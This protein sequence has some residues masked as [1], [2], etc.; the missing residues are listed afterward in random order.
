MPL[1]L[2]MVDIGVQLQWRAKGNAAVGRANVKDIA[3]VA[4]AGVASGI[5]VA[6]YVVVGGRLAPA[7]VSPI[8]GAGVRGR[9]IAR[10]ATARAT[11][12]GSRVGVSPGVASVGGPKDE[13]RVVVGEASAAFVHTGDVHV[14]C[15]QIAGDLDV[16]DK[17]SAGGNLSRVCPRDPIV[18]RVPDKEGAPANIEV[19]PRNVHPAVEGRRWVIVSPARLSV[20][21]R[22]RVNAVMGPAIRV[23]GSGGLVPAEAKTAAGLVDPDGEPSAGWLVI[24]N[25]WVAHR[26]GEGAVT[27]GSRDAGEGAATVGGDRCAGDVE[28]VG[29]DVS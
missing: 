8:S 9:E 6:N 25:N 15:G 14:A 28:R 12:G 19:V 18:S 22:V 4:V 11:E 5:D 10:R 26:I 20:V 27:S 3:G 16:A 24:Q 7:L 21:L 13:I 17:G 2:G 29:G 1:R 23:P